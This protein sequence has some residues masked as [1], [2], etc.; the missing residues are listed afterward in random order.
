MGVHAPNHIS[1]SDHS[2]TRRNR[3]KDFAGKEI[4]VRR[5][6]AHRT[7]GSSGTSLTGRN[8]G[9]PRT[10]YQTVTHCGPP[11][12]SSGSGSMVTM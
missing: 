6:V 7:S 3:T 5:K 2:G 9:N 4:M 8:K 10:T 12:A 11:N 1:G